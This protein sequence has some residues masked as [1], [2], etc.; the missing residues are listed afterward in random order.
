MGGVFVRANWDILVSFGVVHLFIENEESGR[1]GE[2]RSESSVDPR[3]LTCGVD[4]GN[5]MVNLVN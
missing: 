3:R 4:T 2:R 1:F 5:S